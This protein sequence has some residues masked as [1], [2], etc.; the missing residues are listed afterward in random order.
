MRDQAGLRR[1]VLAGAEGEP[2]IDLDRDGSGRQPRRGRATA[3]DDEPAGRRP[4]PASAR[5]RGPVVRCDPGRPRPARPTAPAAASSR[6]TASPSGGL[7]NRSIDPPADRV[8]ASASSS[9]SNSRDAQ[10]VV[11]DAP[12]SSSGIAGP[13]VPRLQPPEV[14]RPGVTASGRPGRSC[15]SPSCGRTSRRRCRACCPPPPPPARSRTCRGRS[16]RRP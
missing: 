14:G 13:T 6:A 11:L 9:I 1:G 15:R 8:G 4:A 7:R 2:G 12:R 10:R 3:V 16:G 5:W